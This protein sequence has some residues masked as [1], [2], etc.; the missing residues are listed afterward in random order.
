MKAVNI[1]WDLTG[2]ELTDKEKE[3]ILAELPTE[4]EIPENIDEKRL[5]I[6]CL[7]NMNGAVVM[8]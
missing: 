2:E 4:V 8:I 7:I 5:M 6:G 3:D 1:K